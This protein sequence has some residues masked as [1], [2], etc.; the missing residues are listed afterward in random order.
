MDYTT[1]KVI[2]EGEAD[3]YPRFAPTMKWDTAAGHAIA[4]YAGVK[5][6]NAMTKEEMPYNTEKL[7]NPWFI[8]KR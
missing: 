6:F 4:K 7:V 8:V 1:G 2:A 3:I 5:M